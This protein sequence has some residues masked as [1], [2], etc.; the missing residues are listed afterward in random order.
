MHQEEPGEGEDEDED[1]EEGEEFDNQEDEEEEEGVKGGRMK[2]KS[3]GRKKNLDT[4]DKVMKI[5][6]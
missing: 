3:V 4:M 1:G 6:G 5:R 2:V